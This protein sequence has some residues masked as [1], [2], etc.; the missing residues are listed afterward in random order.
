MYTIQ[1]KGNTHRVSAAV[2][3]TF[4][5][6]MFFV[7]L[8]MF[9]WAFYMAYLGSSMFGYYTGVPTIVAS[10][11]LAIFLISFTGANGEKAILPKTARKTF[12]TVL[13]IATIYHQYAVENWSI[14]EVFFLVFPIFVLQ[15][16]RLFKKNT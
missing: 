9:A 11:I 16:Y 10:I 2:F 14:L 15:I 8:A 13:F 3:F 7:A 5:I 12:G 4:A 6:P 1:F